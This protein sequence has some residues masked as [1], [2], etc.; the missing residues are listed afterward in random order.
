MYPRIRR[1]RIIGSCH[2]RAVIS[3]LGHF[4][5]SGTG[6]LADQEYCFRLCDPGQL[7]PDVKCDLDRPGFLG[8]KFEIYGH[9]TGGLR[10]H[11]GIYDIP[12]DLGQGHGKLFRQLSSGDVVKR[13]R[14]LLLPP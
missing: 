2:G 11:I 8:L 9:P 1:D 13:D 14:H 6:I 5:P 3:I 7:C 4:H 12:P 10:I